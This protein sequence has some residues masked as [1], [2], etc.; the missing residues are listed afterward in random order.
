MRQAVR[1]PL[2][3][4]VAA[5]G[6]FAVAGCS[7][8]APPATDSCATAG[9]GTV[10]SVQV[11][12]AGAND[13]AG[14]PSAFV[15][16]SDGDGVPLIHGNQGANMIGLVYRVFGAAAPACLG[17]RTQIVDGSGAPITSSTPPLATYA[18]PDGTRLTRPLWLPADYPMQF[19]VDV[20]CADKALSLHLHLLAP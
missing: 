18:Q 19:V 6:P 2:L 5:G 8:G 16:L 1:L 15:A 4:L 14:Q 11:G 12:A 9:A 7:H 3:L 10:D 17:Q 20:T 13:L